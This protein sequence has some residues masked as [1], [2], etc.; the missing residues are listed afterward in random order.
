LEGSSPPFPSKH[1]WRVPPPA[2]VVAE[3]HLAPRR[4]LQERQICHL[5]DNDDSQSLHMATPGLHYPLHVQQTFYFSPSYFLGFGQL[6]FGYTELADP[7][8]V[9]KFFK[10]DQMSSLWYYHFYGQ[11]NGTFA[12]FHQL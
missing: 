8:S 6:A 7:E 2:G 3:G 1:D 11:I 10:A 9:I 12:H 4:L 5:P